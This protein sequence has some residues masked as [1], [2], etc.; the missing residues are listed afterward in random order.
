MMEGDILGRE[1]WNWGDW[2]S[3]MGTKYSENLLESLKVI[4]MRT[5][6]NG[7]YGNPTRH[8]L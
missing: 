2:G 1:A 3:S 8:L 5:H 7:V 4:L 6:S